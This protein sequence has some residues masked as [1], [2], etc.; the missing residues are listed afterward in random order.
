ME[1]EQLDTF[2]GCAERLCN[3]EYNQDAMTNAAAPM[4]INFMKSVIFGELIA[5]R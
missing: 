5:D 4:R 2:I 1:K 3:T